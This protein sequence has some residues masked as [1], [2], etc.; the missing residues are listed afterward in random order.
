[1]IPWPYP[2]TEELSFLFG[3]GRFAP[4]WSES[5]RITGGAS[6]SRVQWG[7]R[8]IVS[9]TYEFDD[10]T[11]ADVDDE[12]GLLLL[13]GSLTRTVTDNRL[14]PTRGRSLRFEARGA[15]DAVLS[16]VSMLRGTAEARFLRQLVGPFRGFARG[17]VGGILTPDFERLPPGQRFVTGGVQTVRGYTYESLGPQDSN[18]QLVGGNLLAIG[19]VELECRFLPKLG[20]A[21]FIDSGNSFRD[22]IDGKF[23]VGVGTGFR[24]VSPVGMV[25]LDGAWGISRG[26]DPFHIHFMIGPVL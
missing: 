12:T 20:L 23:Q 9:L 11:I 6:M 16:D 7:W 13:T 1:V 5:N 2:R 25:R 22:R 14:D 10:W 17:L 26:D 8:E 18:G 3:V 21:G 15:H 24:W 19:S 4:G